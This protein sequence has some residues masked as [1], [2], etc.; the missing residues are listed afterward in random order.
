VIPNAIRVSLKTVR[1]K[2]AAAIE[3]YIRPLVEADGGRIELID[4]TEARVVVRLSGA[5]SGCPGQPYTV[6]RIIEPALR[7]AL[8]VDVH[9]EA[10]F[11]D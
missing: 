5:C 8:G 7:R 4:A 10:R 9:V 3:Q 6:S 11:G 2:A 1:D